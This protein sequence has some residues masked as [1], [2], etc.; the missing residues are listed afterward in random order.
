MVKKTVESN[1]YNEIL[2]VFPWDFTTPVSFYPSEVKER[3]VEYH[4]PNITH[5]PLNSPEL[6]L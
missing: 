2:D 6:R 5:S 4:S 1:K 3:L